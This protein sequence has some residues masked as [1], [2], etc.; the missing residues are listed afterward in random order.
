MSDNDNC[1]IR[2]WGA[3]TLGVESFTLPLSRFP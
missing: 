2:G 3:D 1:L